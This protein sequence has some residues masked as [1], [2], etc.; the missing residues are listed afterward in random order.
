MTSSPHLP[1]FSYSNATLW[2]MLLSLVA[3]ST[4]NRNNDQPATADALQSNSRLTLLTNQTRCQLFSNKCFIQIILSDSAMVNSLNVVITDCKV[5]ER[6][7]KLKHTIEPCHLNSTKLDCINTYK[8]LHN[9]NLAHLPNHHQANFYLFLVYV[10]PS[11]VGINQVEFIIYHNDTTSLAPPTIITTATYIHRL[12]VTAPERLIDKIMLVYVAFFSCVMSIIMGVLLDTDALIKI[13]RMPIAVCIGFISQYVI[14]PLL[15]F[16]FIKVFQLPPI[17]SL[18]LFIYGCSPGGSAS[19]NWTIMFN[20]DIDLSAIMT[21]VS[22]VSSLFMMPL[23]ILTLGKTF[24]DKAHLK[25]PFM[26]LISNL[27]FTIVP[28]LLG[29]FLSRRFP[30]FKKLM[31]KITKQL[32]L[33]LI[34]SFFAITLA[35]KFYIFKLITWQQWVAGPLIPWSGFLF[36]ALLA[37][38]FK[39]EKKQIYTISIETGMQNVGIAFMIILF[40]FSSPE[41]DYAMLPLIPVAAL[42][43]L[44]L[45]VGLL[46]KTVRDNYRGYKSASQEADDVVIEKNPKE[47]ELCNQQSKNIN[48]SQI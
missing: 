38:I 21:F 25:I 6:T 41:S 47:Q 44:P 35:S 46:I 13:I 8:Q 15:S 27:L 20:G 2:L 34:V 5:R 32:V 30:K 7:T 31:L 42:T 17:E 19:N 26:R 29:M 23:W 48:I 3:T 11:L 40:N 22:T 43:A 28:C 12:V 45:W 4:I 33:T 14:M 24:T 10:K 16:A 39:R 36:G 37:W 18:A 9:N 1:L